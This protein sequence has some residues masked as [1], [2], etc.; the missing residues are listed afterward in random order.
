[1]NTRRLDGRTA[2]V[3]GAA[4]GLGLAIVERLMQEGAR[5]LLA[6]IDP[7]VAEIAARLG[8]PHAFADVSRS[9][10]IEA[11]FEASDR[12]F[13]G[14]DIL[15]NNAGVIG[16]PATLPDLAETEFDR[17]MAVNVKS[18]L[19]ATQ[20]AA[21]RMIPRRAGVV[22]NM[23][24]VMA[25]LATGNQIPYSVSKGAVKQLTAATALSLAPYGI[26]VNAVGPGTIA[27]PMAATVTGE[28]G[29]ALGQVL[30]R[31]PLGRLGR[32]EEIAAVVAFLASDDAS[33][34]TGQTIF[35]DGGRQ[36][37]AYFAEP[38][39]EPA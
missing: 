32:P 28:K 23:A 8:Q 11:L 24:S 37:L 10:D 25:V 33:Y 5:V 9:A 1:M 15:V 29:E 34:M 22:V 2:V 7:R 3:T 12:A 26:R 36:V 18:A 14:L 17:V 20:A 35:V 21:R 27:T 30:S 4:Q 13:G 38:L 31:T 39:A 6:D 19:L 16:Q